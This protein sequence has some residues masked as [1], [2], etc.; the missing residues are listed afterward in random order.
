MQISVRMFEVGWLLNNYGV[1]HSPDYHAPS[2]HHGKLMDRLKEMY[3]I[4]RSVL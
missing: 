4:G 2:G 1:V 3:I